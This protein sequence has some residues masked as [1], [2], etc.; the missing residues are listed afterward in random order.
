MHNLIIFGGTFDPIHNGHLNTAIN[1]QQQFQF[2]RFI[3]LPC[4]TPVLKN[5]AQATP[6]Q[7]LA[8]LSLAIA[9]KADNYHF[10][11]DNREIKRESPSYMVTTLEDYRRQLGNDIAIT[12]L[13]GADSFLQLP[14]WHHWQELIKLAHI[15]VMDRPHSVLTSL[16][17]PL[18]SFFNQHVT[19]LPHE[20][21]TRSYG[22][23]YRY[24]AGS[25]DIS[26]TAVR[27]EL[28]GRRESVSVPAG[29]VEYIRR[30]QLYFPSP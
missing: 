13:V 26:S 11:I 23:I 17:E 15:M 4:K 1:I 5:N 28:R 16:Q 21:K 12:L 14:K 19:D 25:Y 8:M 27:E 22:F 3:F 30:H 9:D 29:V 10:E 20:L 18:D 2:E 6:E 7:R 24:N